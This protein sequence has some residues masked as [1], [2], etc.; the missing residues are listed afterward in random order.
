MVSCFY[1]GKSM[2]PHLRFGLWTIVDRLGLSFGECLSFGVG[3]GFA[4][5]L[6]FG[7]GVGFGLE[8]V[9]S[10]GGAKQ[11]LPVAVATGSKAITYSKGLKGRHQH[12]RWRATTGFNS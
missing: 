12:C 4:V 7:V 2:I 11:Q 9:H 5:G 6:G 8:L 3:L 1:A 10:P